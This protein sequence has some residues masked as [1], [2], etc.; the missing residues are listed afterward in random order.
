MRVQT[1][2]PT[3]GPTAQVETDSFRRRDC[4]TARC[5]E[6]V[7]NSDLSPKILPSSCAVSSKKPFSPPSEVHPG[8][9]CFCLEPTCIGGHRIKLLL[10]LFYPRLNQLEGR[11]F[12]LCFSVTCTTADPGHSCSRDLTSTYWL[13]QALI[14]APADTSNR[15]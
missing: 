11:K 3:Y 7:H 15:Q 14:R 2:R 1:L 4:G 6:S 8:Q 13:T 12:A 5:P 10:L 9:A